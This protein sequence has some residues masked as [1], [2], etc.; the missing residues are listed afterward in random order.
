MELKNNKLDSLGR[1]IE[2]HAKP[3]VAFKVLKTLFDSYKTV[4]EQ[5]VMD[6]SENFIGNLMF[7]S[8]IGKKIFL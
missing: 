7:V 1:S 3:K 4:N 2:F 8:Q 5:I 6:T